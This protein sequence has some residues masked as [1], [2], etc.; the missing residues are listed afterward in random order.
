MAYVAKLRSEPLASIAERLRVYEEVIANTEPIFELSGKR[1]E[2]ILKEHPQ[3]LSMYSLLLQEC[4]TIEQYV[5]LKADEQE[6]L[7]FRKYHE[8]QARALGPSELKTYVR[9]DPSY[10]EVKAVLVE[11]NHVKRH[12]ESIVGA[13]EAMSWSLSNITKLRVAEME[14]VIL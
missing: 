13:L 12:L 14:H 10:I 1:L 7:L 4:K 8:S 3:N 11:V 5:E 6:G 9:S 2:A